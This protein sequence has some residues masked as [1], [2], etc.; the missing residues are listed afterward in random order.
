[1]IK[2]W[3]PQFL[4][5]L[6][7]LVVDGI[8]VRCGFAQEGSGVP[9]ERSSQVKEIVPPKPPP[10]TDLP[11][12]EDGG[13][14]AYYMNIEQAIAFL[15]ARA[16]AGSTDPTLLSRLG[17]AYLFSAQ[18]GGGIERFQ[19]AEAVLRRALEIAPQAAQTN[20]LLA[21]ALLGQH[22]FEEA[23]A[24]A[25]AV[26]KSKPEQLDA[27]AA[28]GDALLE[29]GQYEK[30]LQVFEDLQRSESGPAVLARL[31]HH[32]ERTGQTDQ[33]IKLMTEAAEVV[34]STEIVESASFWFEVQ[35]GELLLNAG[36][37]HE[38]ETWFQKV[39][40]GADPYHD[41]TAGLAR[42]QA[43]RG[44]IESAMELFEKAVEIGPDFAMVVGLATLYLREGR[45]ED[46]RPILQ[47]LESELQGR[48]ESRRQLARLYC[49][50]GR[51]LEV[52]EEL[53]RL[54]LS[55]RQDVDGYVTLALVLYLRNAIDE[56]AETIDQALQVG[57]RDAL[58]YDLGAR[59][60][61]AKGDQARAES[62]RREANEINPYYGVIPLL[63]PNP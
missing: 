46:A 36:R 26:L 22:R 42:I 6:T 3:L 59:I 2:R 53:A 30:A 37:L 9:P 17:Q 32:A 60:F 47:E 51:N 12:P 20:S 24:I 5:T 39:E 41:A 44:D 23:I 8:V 62:L 58:M 55:E 13:P 40:P 28:L 50:Q 48:S 45:S 10:P 21:V 34:E 35:V 31:A 18:E 52:A 43:A 57:T 33:A 29:T 61:E 4:I 14:R 27:M 25:E 15:E 19:Q 1:M 54:D 38:S 49:F 7:L 63:P 11:P 16:N 56:A